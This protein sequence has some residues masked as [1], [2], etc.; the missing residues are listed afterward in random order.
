MTALSK[1]TALHVPI[2]QRVP[3]RVVAASALL[4]TFIVHG[5]ANAQALPPITVSPFELPAPAPDAVD[6]RTRAGQPSPVFAGV[7]EFPS[8][9]LLTGEARSR[10]P[11]TLPP[12]R[13]Q[14]TPALT[15]TYESGARNGL[16]GRGW[17]LRLPVVRRS[18]RHGT[19]LDWDGADPGAYA[20]SV[21]TLT[22]P[23]ATVQ[24]DTVLGTSGAYTVY[25]SSAEELMLRAWF[26]HSANQW[27]ITDKDGI[28]YVFGADS[29]ARV[30]SDISQA[31]YTF[32][33]NITSATDPSGNR[34]GYSYY[35]YPTGTYNPFAYPNQIDYGA[36]AGAGYTDTF[37]VCFAYD[38]MG[39]TCTAPDT[40]R[41]DIV[42]S[43]SGAFIAEVDYRVAGIRTWV[44]GESSQAAPTRWYQLHYTQDPSSSDSQL[45]AVTL[46]DSINQPLPS[47]TF[48]YASPQIGMASS[49]STPTF[50]SPVLY[51][52][53]R[54]S[55]PLQGNLS[56]LVDMNGDGLP[57]RF[58]IDH[59]GWHVSLNLGNGA[60]GPAQSWGLAPTPPDL[61]FGT[62]DFALRDLVDMNGDGLPDWVDSN[63]GSR[64][65]I[66]FNTGSGFAAKVPWYL[67]GPAG[68]A[69]PIDGYD[70]AGGIVDLNGDGL[71]D[72]LDPACSCRLSN[73]SGCV[74]GVTPGSCRVFLNTGSGFDPMGVE[75]SWPP[76][77]DYNGSNYPNDPWIEAPHQGAKGID[78]GFADMNGDGL[79]DLVLGPGRGQPNNWTIYFNTGRGFDLIPVY[80]AAPV[81][82]STATSPNSPMDVQQW[83]GMT[84]YGLQGALRDMNGDGRPDYVDSNVDCN[85][86]TAGGP[87][88]VFIN[89][90]TGFAPP[91]LW[92][93][94]AGHLVQEWG[95]V[96]DGPGSDDVVVTA[97]T[98]DV[99]GDK[100]PDFVSSQ[101]TGGDPYHPLVIHLG[102][103]SFEGL[104]THSDNGLGTTVDL[105]YATDITPDYTAFYCSGGS[106]DGH[107]AD[108]SF[109]CPGGAVVNYYD[110]T[111]PTLISTIHS[112]FPVAV[113][114]SS[115]TNTGF[116]GTGNI[117]T[118]NYEFL[119]PY[120]DWPEREFRGFRSS[121]ELDQQA[122]RRHVFEYIQPGSSPVDPVSNSAAFVPTRPFKGKE[123]YR[124]TKEYNS[125]HITK[126][127][128]TTWITATT[129]DPRLSGTSSTRVLR[130]TEV[131]TLHGS[132]PM[133][134]STTVRHTDYG[135]DSYNNINNNTRYADGTLVS[136]TVT[137]FSYLSVPW[138][139]NRPIQIVSEDNTFS[140]I[141]VKG[142]AYDAQGNVI[143]LTGSLDIDPLGGS[144]RVI[145]RE[146]LAYSGAPGTAGQPTS[147]TDARG[148]ITTLAYTGGSCDTHGLYPCQITNT[149]SQTT[150]RTYRLGFGVVATETDANGATVAYDYDSFGRLHQIFRPLLFNQDPTTLSP[151]KR[152]T[153]Q[154]G[155]PGNPPTPSTIQTELFEP[156]NA[157]NFRKEVRF[158]DGLGRLIETKAD[159]IVSGSALTVVREAIGF[160]A[161]G[162]AS[163]RYVP[164][165]TA[166]A[167][168]TYDAPTGA[169]TTSVF[170]N[171][172]RVTQVTQ[173][174][175]NVR[176]IAY[177][178]AGVTDTHDENYVAC[179]GAPG[180]IANASCPGKRTVETRDA[181]ARLVDVK[182]YRGAAT[183]DSDTA[184]QYDALDR[185]VSTELG[186]D[187]NTLVTYTYDSLG[188]RIQVS[189]KDS[190][191][192]NY[193]YD[194]SGNLVYEDDPKEN[195]H[196]EFCF[197]QLNR[198]S[199]KVSFTNDTYSGNPCT[200]GTSVT[201]YYYDT[202]LGGVGRLCEEKSPSRYDVQRTFD[203]RGRVASEQRQ[204]QAAGIQRTLSYSFVYDAADR[205][206]TLNYP[207][208]TDGA[209]ETLTYGYDAAGQLASATTP[210]DLYLTNA[211][212]D[213]F[214]RP[215]DLTL[216]GGAVDEIRDYFP[217]S[218]NF[219]LQDTY[220]R[221]GT[222]AL[223][224]W[225][226]GPT[227]GGTI[228]NGY[229]RIGNLLQVDDVTPQYAQYSDT[230][231]DW[232]YT[233]DGTGRL[234]SAKWGARSW[235]ATFQYD[236]IG[237]MMNGNLDFPTLLST[238]QV[239]FTPDPT[240]RHH[241]AA[242]TGGSV[243]YET[244]GTNSDGNGGLQSRP[245]T[246]P[247]DS[248]QVVSY[249]VE[250][251]VLAVTT[252]DGIVQNVYD[253]HGQRIAR[254]VN[255]SD[256]TFYFGR[257]VELHG[258]QVIR[259]I[260]A[261]DRHVAFS[262]IPAA[263]GLTLAA[264]PNDHPAV[265]LARA[266]EESAWLAT[267]R[268]ENTD[269]GPVAATGGILIAVASTLVL[270]LI[271]GRVSVGI[272]RSFRRGRVA[273]LVLVYIVSLPALRPH[274]PRSTG[275]PRA[276]A[277]CGPQPPTF[278][279]Y[280]VHVD[281]LGSTTL[282]TAYKIAAQTDG[283]VMEYYRYGP[284]GRMQ[285]YTPSGSTVASGSEL[286]DTTFT[287]QRWDSHAHLYYYGA[288]FY[289]PMIARFATMD[290]ERSSIRNGQGASSPN[291]SPV[292]PS[293]TSNPYMNPYAYVTWCPTGFRDP[294]GMFTV[295]D[296]GGVAGINWVLGYHI[297]GGSSG[298]WGAPLDMEGLGGG[299]LGDVS[300]ISGTAVNAPGAFGPS[301]SDIAAAQDAAVQSVQG[302]VT[303]VAEAQGASQGATP[304]VPLPASIAGA[305][306]HADAGYEAMYA[307][308]VNGFVVLSGIEIA[309][310]FAETAVAGAGMVASGVEAGSL[311]T[312]VT[313]AGL[314]AFS[315][316]FIVGGVAVA[317]IVA[318]QGIGGL[319]G[320]GM[321]ASVGSSSPTSPADARP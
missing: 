238:T 49:A 151:W 217:A 253:D 218:G 162:R 19:P 309:A 57:D 316:V 7:A 145:T 66:A 75:W 105:A 281:H 48:T 171:L 229:D 190:G 191:T 1:Q 245:Q 192:W 195:Q 169:V 216:S 219:R 189:E 172:D 99:N 220:V 13:K 225:N 248:A 312:I 89:T 137:W 214:G 244:G 227:L 282:L 166:T 198:P 201:L 34:I 303:K 154:F 117:L 126:E 4:A 51:S 94:T 5:L 110:F 304:S 205:L 180:S 156:A 70:G 269:L 107:I 120:F 210:G 119:A 242:M 40:S 246:V 90:G 155:S 319:P 109:D 240:R 252:S 6:P 114:R 22:L 259:H 260:F 127:L 233:Y 23:S 149:L 27:I 276:E 9:D 204:I 53:L 79:P 261:G 100:V 18:V 8:V 128:A 305:S 255:G 287:G 144:P 231:N 121:A 159:G 307:Q 298:W 232:L 178:P 72:L 73:A 150:N 74:S 80:W 47:S 279:A 196:L 10:V 186:A 247:D 81:T 26:N 302:A 228:H 31:G 115:T 82:T 38:S 116:S 263:P 101:A 20:D 11:I 67:P 256:V 88:R 122:T 35:S 300:S 118:K 194:D 108:G 2:L 138:I 135:Y 234:S 221:K 200:H 283:A 264:L 313:G 125:G 143:K 311:A 167:V 28:Q 95:L 32:G 308:A 64:W 280:A 113:V 68:G 318:Y 146:T 226:Y 284:Y 207:T 173:P 55:T 275:T 236:G 274:A 84:D 295:P 83:C 299:L 175:S 290:P 96:P 92:P 86:P 265:M 197:D 3:A 124:A 170:D 87:W 297:S 42:Y 222:T 98:L 314:V 46:Y 76:W 181:L 141:G 289:D 139:V 24:L 257:Y 134:S 136:A 208:S 60:F 213:V 152:F 321:G 183:L 147:L 29:N 69:M 230:D 112:P 91:V 271:P 44:D 130:S 254:I 133:G 39:N 45:S 187:A 224:T 266:A 270:I 185:L 278:P 272:F 301:G 168:G 203:A 177:E 211:T 93:G 132:D 315:S 250:G 165:T 78:T 41:P 17:D 153:Y 106:N 131:E 209:P 102:L 182:V 277:Q 21:F 104:L 202:C 258:S 58:E 12:G 33:W 268:S 157:N 310:H 140:P 215:T 37:H 65:W 184:Y 296:A 174:D 36:N 59:N 103:P 179:N 292:L 262:P 251:R 61:A 293:L 193:G 291:A 239:A 164:R 15:L 85:F 306:A 235:T 237:N 249:D 25:A 212:Y 129:S 14:M 223:Q 62:G 317:G 176:N 111:N 243:N 241:I 320:A 77:P 161:A 288:R 97:D 54:R 71:P 188:R 30:G 286:T 158:Y 285:A 43:Y 16:L 123:S 199:I 56:D 52:P 142:F 160:D 273:A 63:D 206:S 50:N 294:S 267:L 148:N 163:Q